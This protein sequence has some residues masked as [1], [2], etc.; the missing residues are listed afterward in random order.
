MSNGEEGESQGNGGT[1]GKKEPGIFQE[2]VCA[3]DVR[4]WEGYMG[5]PRS[6]TGTH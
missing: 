6:R 5:I 3:K 4:V 1:D 2:R